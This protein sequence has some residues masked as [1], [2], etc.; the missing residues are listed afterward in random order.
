MNYENRRKVEVG[1]SKDTER[2]TT[3]TAPGERFYH[4]DRAARHTGSS[5]GNVQ[6]TKKADRVLKPYL[7]IKKCEI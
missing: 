4:R 2:T 1:N 5:L 7:L 6:Q 3:F